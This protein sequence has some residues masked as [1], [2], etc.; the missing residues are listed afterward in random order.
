VITNLPAD[1]PTVYEPVNAQADNFILLREVVIERSLALVPLADVVRR[2][3]DDQSGAGSW[4]LAKEIA[5]IS[6]IEGGC[7]FT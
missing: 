1:T 3:R 7:G 6:G 5:A 4:D 2:R